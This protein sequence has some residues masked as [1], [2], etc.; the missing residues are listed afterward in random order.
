MAKG[1]DGSIVIEITGDTKEL[2]KSLKAI[3]NEVSKGFSKLA[4]EIEKLI[5]SIGKTG[6]E[7]EKVKK[8][9]EGIGDSAK[10]GVE[11]ATESVKKLGDSSRDASGKAKTLSDTIEKIGDAAKKGLDAAVKSLA[12]VGA[13]LATAAGFA[14]KFGSSFESEMSNLAAIT[15]STAD[16]MK[17]MEEGI[18]NIALQSGRSIAEIAG[19]AKMVAE[20]GGDINLMM[21][22]M[23]HGVNLATATQT[24]MATT[25]DFLGSTMK[26]F[27]IDVEDTQSV[28]DSFAS[29]TSLANVELS[30]L[31][32]AYVNMGGAAADAGISIDDVN[33]MLITMANAGLKGG[34]AG[35]SLNAVLRNLSTPT[36]K[37]AAE[38]DRLNISLYNVATGASRDMTDIMKDL[39]IATKN[40]TDEQRKR[41]ESIIFDSVAQ[42]RQQRIS[43][44]NRHV[45]RQASA[46]RGRKE[47][48]GDRRNIRQIQS[49]GRWQFR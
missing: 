26:T 36:E 19:N 25:L 32:A 21:E 42:K 7:S 15:G 22:Q 33:S 23:Q 12:A 9:T 14:Y 1:S 35:T 5:V 3:D 48:E 13:G 46:I 49:G 6:D 28:V 31:S 17:R 27:G 10:K 29:V 43:E 24:D 37:A 41:T 20:A 45:G 16:E 34:A 39:E 2:E 44:I 30:Q 8:S 18:R 40:M 38:L 11:P 4:R 47:R